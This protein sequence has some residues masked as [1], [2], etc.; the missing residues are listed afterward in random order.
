MPA[1]K[2]NRIATLVIL[3]TIVLVVASW[4]LSEKAQ[5]SDAPDP[6]TD[7][8]RVTREPEPADLETNAE[9]SSIE[10]VADVEAQLPERPEVE[11]DVMFFMKQSVAAF[12]AGS[13]EEEQRLLAEAGVFLSIADIREIHERMIGQDIDAYFESLIKVWV[14]ADPEYAIDFAWR[15]FSEMDKTPGESNIHQF[16]NPWL[17]TDPEAAL[18]FAEEYFKDNPD[19]IEKI[20]E[21]VR[22]LQSPISVAIEMMENTKDGRQRKLHE[23]LNDWPSE[24]LEN[25]VQWGMSLTGDDR[26]LVVT[27][28]IRQLAE[29]DPQ[30]ALAWLPRLEALEDSSEYKEQL[31]LGLA[32]SDPYTASTMLDSLSGRVRTQAVERI[33]GE[34][35]AQNPDQAVTWLNNLPDEDFTVALGPV[36]SSLPPTEWQANVDELLTTRS[37]T[38]TTALLK[39]SQDLALKN[40]EFASGMLL[41]IVEQEFGGEFPAENKHNDAANYIREATMQIAIAYAINDGAEAA[42][43]WML[44]AP[45]NE[46]DSRNRQIKQI[47]HGLPGARENVEASLE[48]DAWTP[49]QRATLQTILEKTP[50]DAAAPQ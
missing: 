46:E 17:H 41:Y 45:Y 34:V 21:N 38:S 31:V 8:D 30:S 36:L 33:A 2:R 35:A 43:R 20:K 24:Q 49:E 15:M 27:S 29:K 26:Q 47:V 48:T 37:E 39:A 13:L 44:R 42:V 25:G 10:E 5:W 50:T 11:P 18:A 7:E 22:E 23:H 9:I 14:E 40:R 28:L 1:T 16:F 4:L 3:A 6:E 19:I 32:A 12:S